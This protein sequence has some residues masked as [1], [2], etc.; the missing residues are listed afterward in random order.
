MTS[1]LTQYDVED[2]HVYSGGV[3]KYEMLLCCF[4]LSCLSPKARFLRLSNSCESYW[5]EDW[6]SV[7]CQTRNILPLPIAPH[8]L[9]RI[10]ARNFTT[11][12]ST[13]VSNDCETLL[14][15]QGL[16]VSCLYSPSVLYNCNMSTVGEKVRGQEHCCHRVLVA[17]Q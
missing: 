10:R 14:R 9:P 7:S 11:E 12:G 4:P 6:L 8:K 2:L 1:E 16:W 17:V 15:N 3:C 5:A 13:S